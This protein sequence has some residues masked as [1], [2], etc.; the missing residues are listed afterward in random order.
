MKL[1]KFFLPLA[2]LSTTIPVTLSLTSCFSELNPPSYKTSD[3][4]FGFTKNPNETTTSIV[5]VWETK[6]SNYW[7]IKDT[8][9]L[10]SA[11]NDSVLVFPGWITLQNQQAGIYIEYD[12]E[13]PIEKVTVNNA[14]LR[15]FTRIG[16]LVDSLYYKPYSA[17]VDKDNKPVLDINN[18][19][20]YN[21]NLYSNLA[22]IYL[23]EST[24][25][26]PDNFLNIEDPRFNSLPPKVEQPDNYQSGYGYK[27]LLLTPNLKNLDFLT[28]ESDTLLE[29][30][31]PANIY[32][33]GKNAFANTNVSYGIDTT[34]LNKDNTNRLV[35]IDQNA[36]LNVK[37]VSVNIDKSQ[38]KI[39][40][41]NNTIN[42]R[43]NAFALSNLSKLNIKAN[44]VNIE[45]KAFYKSN[46]PSTVNINT[47]YDAT[48]DNQQK[49]LTLTNNLFKYATGI[50]ELN[51]ENTNV[52]LSDYVFQQSSTTRL[53]TKGLSFTTESIN[54]KNNL[55][56][57]KELSI[58]KSFTDDNKTNDIDYLKNIL[59]NFPKLKYFVA[60]PNIEVETNPQTF[61]EDLNNAINELGLNKTVE[62][63]EN[64]TDYFKYNTDDETKIY[65][66]TNKTGFDTLNQDKPINWVLWGSVI[67]AS[68]GLILIAT[69]TTIVIKKKKKKNK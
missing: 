16:S 51:C 48:V 38:L 41:T 5:P 47:I 64:P 61:V 13:K 36:F 28:D 49:E 23:R 15:K 26:I 42:I 29:K 18:A 6:Q 37:D 10:R 27:N 68:V 66:T 2:L 57:I 54:S 1:K 3:T 35:N 17:I 53:K 19:P 63:I 59:N 20:T 56:D 22:R 55:N 32:S 65:I 62:L 40:D 4:V 45:E 8:Q 12:N 39:D 50:N 44:Q 69:I 43:K 7:K 46:L 60:T 31:F 67:G 11:K 52:I 24:E 30:V 14:D 21:F 34:K 25:F 33:I 58:T 9:N